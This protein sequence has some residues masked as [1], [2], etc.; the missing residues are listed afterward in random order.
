MRKSAGILVTA[1]LA[2]AMAGCGQPHDEDV[3][4]VAQRFYDAYSAKHGGTACSQL[5]PETRSELEQS[6]GKP[7]EEAVT[8]EDVPTVSDL[9]DVRVYGTQAE[10]K[11]NGDTTFLAQFPGGWKVIAAACTPQPSGPYD[12]TIS[13]G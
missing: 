13:G 9:V 3:E 8:E 11:W 12:C 6:S 4:A 1:A 10:V 7:C 5:A 2:L